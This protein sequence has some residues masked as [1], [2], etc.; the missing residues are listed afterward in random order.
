VAG[1]FPEFKCALCGRRIDPLGEFFRASGTF[2]PP[3]DPL[4]GYCGAP[5]H[6]SC[7][8]KWPERPRFARHYVDAWQ[9]ANRRNPFWWTVYRDERVYISVNPERPV[10]EASVRLCI[11]GSDIRVPLPRWA[12]WLAEVQDVT[13]GLRALEREALAEVLPLLRQ[14]FPDDYAV[15]QAIDPDEKRAGRAGRRRAAGR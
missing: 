14:R 8:A 4:S 11:I 12:A 7:Y 6:W 9:D 5:L 15:V 1:R 10:E 13:P 2:L 3:G